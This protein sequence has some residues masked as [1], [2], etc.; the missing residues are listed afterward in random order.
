MLRSR[1]PLGFEATNERWGRNIAKVQ[2][3]DLEEINES[4]KRL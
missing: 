1:A 3:G 2:G 4:L